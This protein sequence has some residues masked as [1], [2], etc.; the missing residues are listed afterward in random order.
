MQ[1]FIGFTPPRLLRCRL[2]SILAGCLL[3]LAPAYAQDADKESRPTLVRDAFT[4]ASSLGIEALNDNNIFQTPTDEFSSPIWKLKPNLLM[5]FEPARSR[6][7]FG[8]RGDYGWYDKSSDDDYADHALQ[9]GAYLLLG[10]RSGL[11]LVASYKDA[12][13]NR[14]TGLTQGLDPGSGA[15]PSGPD[16]YSNGQVL[17]R[18]TYGVSR[19][20][21]FIALEAST[22]KLAYQNDLARTR[23]FDRKE[24]HGQATFGIRVQPKTSVELRAE[25]RDIK[26]DNAR[27]SGASP[28]SREYRYL[29]GVVWEA[30]GRTTGSVRM[31]GVKR[32]F[33]DSARRDF[34]GPN[35]EVA[36]RW[37]PRTYSHFDLATERYTEE[38]IVL[39][40][41]VTDT[42]VYSLRW[43][44]E[45][46]SRLA[47]KLGLSKFDR[48]YRY[49][50]GDS[51]EKNT[52]ALIYTMRPWLRW[53]AG[54]D[55]NARDSDVPSYN[56]HQNIAGRGAR[57]IV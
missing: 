17:G 7:E 9:A 16:R 20:R 32:K 36:I 2:C 29:L 34:S 8:Y 5:R 38:P 47:S 11:D 52:L 13:E 31:G 45:W 18:F 48:T 19:T 37:S 1:N 3:L 41:D 33:D 30:T 54:L 4:L 15:F 14:G 55:I 51:K 21:A 46:N 6:L 44:H 35:W 40:G 26:Y 12:H 42:T 28:D 57:I 24:S 10:A 50:T 23:Q 43:S 53:D 27:A 56:A 39:F 25:V 49:L 22:Q